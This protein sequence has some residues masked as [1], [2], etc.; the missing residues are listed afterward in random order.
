[1]KIKLALDW[2]PN[3]NHIGFFIAKELGYF[4]MF[5]LNVNIIDPRDDNYALTPAK[6]VELGKADLASVSYTHLTLPT[7]PHV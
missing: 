1:M 3:T 6:K 2:T 4:N 7:S 5:D